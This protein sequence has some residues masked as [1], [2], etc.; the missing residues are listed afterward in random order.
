MKVYISADMEGATEIVVSYS[1]GTG[2]NKFILTPQGEVT[3]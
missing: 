2:L 1:H 3:T